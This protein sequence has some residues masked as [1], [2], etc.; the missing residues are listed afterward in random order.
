MARNLVQ[1]G[2]VITLTAPYE[3]LTGAGCIVGGIFGV[4]LT[5]TA[6]GATGQYATQGVWTLPKLSTDTIDQGQKVYWDNSNKRVTETAT[7]AYKIGAA[8]EAAGNGATTVK[9]KLDG[10]V[11]T[12]EAGS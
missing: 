9:V 5:D 2:A 11:I 6:N 1:D 3:T 12:Q 4:A 7:S 8:V 10:I